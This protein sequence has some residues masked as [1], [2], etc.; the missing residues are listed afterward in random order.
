MTDFFE[1]NT[2]LGIP[3]EIDMKLQADGITMVDDFINFENDTIKHIS[4]NL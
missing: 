3:H 1:M 2:H 4:A